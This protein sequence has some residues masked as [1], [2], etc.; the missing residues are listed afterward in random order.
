MIGLGKTTIASILQEEFSLPVFYEEVNNNK[1]LPLF[2]SASE[3]EQERMRY[4]FL[5][6][7]NFLC[8]RFHAA[9]E[10]LASGKAILDRSI[11][12]DRYFAC[13][14]H[15]LGRISDLEMQTYENIHHEMRDSLLKLLKK[16]DLMIYLKGSFDTCIKRIKNRGRSFE[17][18]PSLEEYYHFLWKDYD[19]WIFDNYKESPILVLAVEAQSSLCEHGFDGTGADACIDEQALLP[20]SYVIAVSATSARKA[21]EFDHYFISSSQYFLM[22]A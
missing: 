10:A 3:E 16:P 15:E 12:E 11:Y 6:Q 13:K 5:L 22:T 2:Y 20:V 1:F 9:K 21:D 17:L 19:S 4:P 14:N 8:S 18:A 7:M